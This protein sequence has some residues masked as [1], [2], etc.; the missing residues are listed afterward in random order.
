VRALLATVPRCRAAA[1]AAALPRCRG[2]GAA[3]LRAAAVPRRAV[4]SRVPVV[5]VLL[6]LPAHARARAHA[7]QVIVER[8]ERSD[9]PDIDKKKCVAAPRVARGRARLACPRPR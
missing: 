1:A 8:A 2:R 7:R 6:A 9:V 3:V 5:L 4:S